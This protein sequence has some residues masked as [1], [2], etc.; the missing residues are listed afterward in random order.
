MASYGDAE[1]TRVKAENG[2][3]YAY[4]EVAAGDRPLVLCSTSRAISTT[5][6]PRWSTSSQ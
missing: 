6:T 1:T 4:R 5:G 3:E 2:V